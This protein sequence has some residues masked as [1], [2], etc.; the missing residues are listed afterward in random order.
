MREQAVRAR[1]RY[2]ARV[3]CRCSAGE[4][5]CRIE[6]SEMR[7]QGLLRALLC[8]LLHRLRQRTRRRAWRL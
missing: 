8:V 5:A 7:L 6:A 3:A 1:W 4:C 2:G